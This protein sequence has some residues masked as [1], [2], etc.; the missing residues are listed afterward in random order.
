MTKCPFCQNVAERSVIRKNY[1]IC[2][3]CE[4]VGVPI[5]SYVFGP[6]RHV[7][8]KKGESLDPPTESEVTN[9]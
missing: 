3:S 1:L 6:D 5:T 7:W 4:A 8:R 2:H 9:D